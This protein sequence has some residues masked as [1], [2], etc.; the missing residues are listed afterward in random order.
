MDSSK[1]AFLKRSL[2]G[3]GVLG[4]VGP[5][6]GFV[7]RVA[8]LLLR[9][10]GEIMTTRTIRTILPGRGTMDGAGVRLKRVFGFGEVPLFDPF[11]LLDDFRNDNPDD[12]I[13]G[14][15]WHPHRGIETVTY[16][17]RGRV[18]HGDSMGNR[19]TL[20][21]GDIQ[22]M[23]AGGG[24]I[25]EE[26]PEQVEGSLFGMQLWVNLPRSHKMMAPRYQDIAGDTVPVVSLPSGG[27]VRVLAGAF[28]GTVG[29]VKD[30]VADPSYF[31]VELT[32]G[33]PFRLDVTAGHTVF[34]Y[35]LMGSGTF[36]PGAQE[37]PFQHV[38]LYNDGGAVEIAAGMN[39]CRFILV[40][41]Q[42]LGE[43]VAWQGPIVMNTDEELATAFKDYRE[44]TFLR[45]D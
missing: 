25:H 4:L 30:V 28:Q 17:I 26:M 45:H 14:F 23:T 13:A 1:R 33:E 6:G 18:K 42:P 22:W 36:A 5:E 41:G 12:Y 8:R 3:V 44:G 40:S 35:L 31:D 15:P 19:G 21:D 16:M 2:A 29:P 7:R 32:P 27:Q 20:N 43:P 39:G 11:L 10:T 9:K 38:V 24:I 34:A 37:T